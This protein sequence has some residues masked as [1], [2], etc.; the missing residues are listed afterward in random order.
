V[1]YEAVRDLG[2]EIKSEEHPF[3]KLI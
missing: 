3:F 1:I 2:I